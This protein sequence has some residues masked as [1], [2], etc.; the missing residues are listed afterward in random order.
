MNK[1]Y[2]LVLKVLHCI[3]III[4]MFEI[5]S[6]MANCS[7][8]SVLCVLNRCLFNRYMV[9]IIIYSMLSFCIAWVTIFNGKIISWYDF[10]V[11]WKVSYVIGHCQ[12]QS[13]TS[14]GLESKIV[15]SSKIVTRLQV[16]S[17]LVLHHWISF[18]N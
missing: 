8:Y 11:S 5:S 1:P 13:F 17:C 18:Y 15:S 12:L 10:L 9:H 2:Y 7:T 14:A 4:M 6:I 3:I 16:R